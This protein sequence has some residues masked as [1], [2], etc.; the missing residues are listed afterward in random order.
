MNSDL[1]L[2]GENLAPGED[3][4]WWSAVLLE[5]KRWEPFS[6]ESERESI[7]PQQNRMDW[8]QA[9]LLM[10]RDEIVVMEVRGYNRGG[11]LVQGEM[12]QGFV[13]LSHLLQYDVSAGEEARHRII[14]N[15]VGSHINLKIIECDPAKDR[16]VFSERAAKA[17]CGKRKEIITNIQVGDI[18]EGCVTNITDFGVF[19]DLGG[20]EGLIHLSE[21]SWG[22]VHQGN[23][24]VRLGEIIRVVV[25]SVNMNN[26]RIALSLKRLNPNPWEVLGEKYH[27]GDV[28]QAVVTTLTRFGAFARLSEGV[29]GLIHISTLKLAPG[30]AL[31]DLLSS[32]QEIH[33]KI[34]HLDIEKRRLGLG[35]VAPE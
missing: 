18:V 27:P 12:L 14:A 4:S 7:K 9:N 15:Y 8:E 34:L 11:L 17:G 20:V 23:E 25:L 21:L 3:E 30:T 31:R 5:E 35:L 32:G 33:V 13:P 24:V 10:A 19:V 1:S 28:V 6:D 29:E 16:I 26:A 22:R 2:G